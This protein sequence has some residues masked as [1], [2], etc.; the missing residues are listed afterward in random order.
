MRLIRLQRSSS[1]KKK[2]SN[3]R[4]KASKK[5]RSLQGV[6]R[7]SLTRE[8]T[9]QSRC[10]R[11]SQA[12]TQAAVAVET[13]CIKGMTKNHHLAKAI[14]DVSWGFFIAILKTK[15]ETNGIHFVKVLLFFALSQTCA[16]YRYKKAEVKDLS[17]ELDM[18]RM[19]DRARS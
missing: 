4:K 6:T 13:L 1:R 11:L 9:M 18:P 7:K 3:N 10:L 17:K 16:E 8:K 15:C 14:N 2:G 19:R 12:K 5:E